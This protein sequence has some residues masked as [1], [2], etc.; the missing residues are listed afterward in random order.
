MSSLRRRPSKVDPSPK[1]ILSENNTARIATELAARI[2][3]EQRAA[4]I[5]SE[6]QPAAKQAARIAVEQQIEEPVAFWSSTPPYRRERSP[7]PDSQTHPLTAPNGLS[8]PFREVYESTA[9][10]LKWACSLRWEPPLR[11]DKEKTPAD[12]LD[13]AKKPYAL[14]QYAERLANAVEEAESRFRDI[15]HALLSVVD[16]GHDTAFRPA[17]LVSK[18]ISDITL[19]ALRCIPHDIHNSVGA[20]THGPGTLE[21]AKRV[22]AIIQHSIPQFNPSEMLRRMRVE[23]CKANTA[24]KRELPSP[25]GPD[26]AIL[27]AS[28][29][30]LSVDLNL[31]TATLDGVTHRLN[32]PASACVLDALARADDRS[33]SSKELHKEPGLNGKRI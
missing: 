1:S 30:R 2:A 9:E 12:K 18:A 5:A 4:E 11:R 17:I 31:L 6:Q 13:T 24:G 8:L 21:S 7:F 27:E 20:P 14:E 26:A 16:P 10:A 3:A 28:P 23:A 25:S 22:A 32:D 29:P 15:E 33:L 19:L